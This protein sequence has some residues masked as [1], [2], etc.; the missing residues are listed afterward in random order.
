MRTVLN[1]F[2]QIQVFVV[3]KFIASSFGPLPCLQC[4]GSAILRAD[5]ARYHTD[6]LAIET[7]TYYMH[8]GRFSIKYGIIM[9]YI[10]HF[11]FET[12][13]FDSFWDP[14]FQEIILIYIYICT[15]YTK[16]HI[17]VY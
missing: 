2:Q 5:K 3:L 15:K 10:D 16:Y 4:V 6:I 13:D 7:Q 14:S 1:H 8:I 17:L 12:N 11:S 9:D